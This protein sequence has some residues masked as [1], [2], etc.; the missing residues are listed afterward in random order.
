MMTQWRDF[1]D[2]HGA[3]FDDLGQA[4]FPE[5]P[6]GEAC[7]LFALTQFDVLLA[8][9]EDAA[10]FLQGQLTND[11]REL[12]A[13]HTQLTALCTQKGRVLAC[14]R[15]IALDEIR[16]LLLPAERI[17][18]TL[19]HL[20]R[21]VLRSRVRLE[22]AGDQ[23]VVLGLAGTEAPTLLE[24]LELAVPA[25]ANG[26]ARRDG[27]AV[28][29]L[30]DT[31]PRYL[32][33]AELERARGLWE[34]LAAH[35][36]PS[37]GAIWRRL[38]I[39]AGLPSVHAGTAE[40]FIPQMLNLQLID[41]VSFNK[42]CYTGQEVVARMHHL[43]KLKR[44]MYRATLTLE[45]AEAPAPQPGDVLLAAA[46]SSG[47]ASGRVVDAAPHGAGRYELLVVLEIAIAE[48]GEAR[49]GEHG[50]VL[51]VQPLPYALEPAA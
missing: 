14:G 5:H 34:A 29:A 49:L 41:G 7:R 51:K 25:H 27:V 38:D 47:Q 18:T 46:S 43:G 22:A 1:L 24:R 48:H 15:L 31:T 35:A 2:A 20:R 13:E 4:R 21:Y 37:D 36:T 10:D 32:L 33:L 12:S 40:A 39:R 3:R 9:G 6:A 8:R 50:P 42:G 45:P 11:V 17:E 44:R 16:A 26:L 30:P 28:V 19:A 23:L